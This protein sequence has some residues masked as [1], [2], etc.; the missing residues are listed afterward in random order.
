M[1]RAHARH[2]NRESVVQPDAQ[3]KFRVTGVLSLFIILSV[4]MRPV[5]GALRNEA[6]NKQ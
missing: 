3:G 4:G 1:P 2:S 6:K 5:N